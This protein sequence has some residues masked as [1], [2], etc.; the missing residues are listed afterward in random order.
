MSNEQIKMEKK[1]RNNIFVLFICVF[2]A[3]LMVIIAISIMGNGNSSKVMSED[4]YTVTELFSS[5]VSFISDESNEVSKKEEE[6]GEDISL[7]DS[8]HVKTSDMYKGDLVLVNNSHLYLFTE[9]S[10]LERVY[11]KKIPEYALSTGE[12]K[13]LERTIQNANYF[14]E[15]FYNVSGLTNLL[16]YNCFLTKEEQQNKYD[17]Y[18]SSVSDAELKYAIKAGASDA[19]TGLS[20]KIMLYPSNGKIGEGEYAW[21]TENAHKY[22]FILRYP[23]DKVDITNVKDENRFRYVGLPHS[24]YMFENNLCLE[25][26]IQLVKT[27]DYSNPIIHYHEGEEYRIYY[28]KAETYAETTEVMVPKGYSY[29]YSGDNDGGFIITA[30]LEN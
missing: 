3:V 14:I 8:Y 11:S 18:V 17:S 24:L 22:G 15:D 2:V 1:S 23:N 7:F 27:R 26:Y 10:P 6:S 25:E 9:D 12:E 29:T 13:L 19:H 20:F 5:E 28:T 4:Y 30:Y 16:M 21:I